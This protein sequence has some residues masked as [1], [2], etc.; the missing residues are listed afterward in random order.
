MVILIKYLYR[1]LFGGF[2]RTNGL[3]NK[4]NDFFKKLYEN[5]NTIDLSQMT[6]TYDPSGK[7][8]KFQKLLLFLLFLSLLVFVFLAQAGPRIPGADAADRLE[9]AGTVLR[10]VDTALFKWGARLFAGISILSA[11]YNLKEQRFGVAI[12]CIIAAIILG[13]APVWVE[14]IF[15]IGGG[16]G[17]FN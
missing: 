6:M 11:G 4:R 10:I 15:S 12:I 7:D 13:T 8:P 3:L 16:D 9:A 17:I 2:L 14:N 5:S 1:K